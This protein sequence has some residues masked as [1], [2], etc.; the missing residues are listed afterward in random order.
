[1]MTERILIVEDEF[2]VAHDLQMILS[3]AGYKVAGVADSVKNALILLD[4]KEVDLVLLDIFLKGK[5]TGIDLARILME[6]Q[7]P[8]IYISA[9]SN[10]RVLEAAKSTLPYGFIVKPYR[11][12]DVL[13]SIDIARYRTNHS[14]NLK[15]SSKLFMEDFIVS[16]SMKPLSWQKKLLLIAG[17]F[18][19]Y[20]PFDFLGIIGITK[21]KLRFSEV[22]ISRK[23]FDEYELLPI[24]EF[25]EA[26]G[27]NTADKK[28][29]H[30]LFPEHIDDAI[31]MG[32]AFTDLTDQVPIKNL[33]AKTYH[34]KSNLI[35]SIRLDNGDLI[36][37]S[38][39]SRLDTIFKQ[40]HLDLLHALEPTLIGNLAHIIELEKAEVS[41]QQGIKEPVPTVFNPPHETIFQ[42]IIGRSPAILN[43]LDQLLI[44]A[45]TDTSVLITGE[46]GTGKEM[47][48]QNLHRLS[49]RR[50]KS[51]V[52]VNCAALPADLIES[53]LFGHEKGAF[54][55]ASNRR[56]GKF[57]EANG[58]TIF[59]DEIGE[60]PFDLQAKLLR[61]LQEK[62]IE[63]V[64]GGTP[65]AVDLR[66]IAATNL[67][68]E[69]EIAKG[70]FRL[71]L[72]FRLNVF[73]LE[74]PS[75]RARKEDIAVL[76][77][78]FIE[79]HSKEL[80]KII[81]GASANF[82][83]QLSRYH[84][85]GNIRELEH[86]IIR[87]ILLSKKPELHENL[88]DFNVEKEEKAA[89][90][91]T[92]TIAENERDHILNVLNQCKGRISG[93]GGAAELLGIPAT[94]LN[95]KMKKLGLRR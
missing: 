33:V 53:I 46:S 57:E 24:D 16:I 84:W 48:A 38:F 6:R 93:P 31:F 50:N 76:A 69:K 22:G 88:L 89:F 10:E 78:Y 25:L 26:S 28:S 56:I 36:T 21:D 87:S 5:Q 4:K 8:F 12:K 86:V 67:N 73:P 40:E 81:T 43:L 79:K 19:P 3:H 74:V 1:M 34:L 60:M 75:L 17:A 15:I 70:K 95:S 20:I 61:V 18:Q 58:G 11:E 52:A 42:K 13:L 92:K 30:S 80:G 64:G 9:N 90:S 72:F 82:M 23:Q 66:I 63:R 83:D 44:V 29:T 27:I 35:K 41:R 49:A 71:D 45:P 94:T 65:I 55:G 54:T 32:E 47:I 51:M 91:S 62:E 14:Q 77:S 7:I 37:F 2:I 85:P 59:L 39:Y 68:L